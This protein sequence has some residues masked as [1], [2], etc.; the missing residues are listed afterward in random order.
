MPLSIT[1]SA[2]GWL[3]RQTDALSRS[4]LLNLLY[5]LLEQQLIGVITPT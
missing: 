3:I 5:A 1:L 4:R 2:I